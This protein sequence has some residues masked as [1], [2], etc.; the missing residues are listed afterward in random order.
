MADCNVEDLMPHSLLQQAGPP[1]RVLALMFALTWAI[2]WWYKDA[3]P[4]LDSIHQELF[5]EP[6]QRETT[7]L[8]FHVEEGGE[9][10]TITPKAEYELHGLV[11]SANDINILWDTYHDLWGD[12][13]NVKDLCV[14][15]GQN[16]RA[17]VLD[18]VT[19][20]NTS[21]TC[22]AEWRLGVPFSMAHLSNNH[23]LADSPQ[24]QHQLRHIGKGDQVRI[25]GYLAQYSNGPEF[26]RD[27]SLTRTDTGMGACETI[28]VTEM[29]VLAEGTPLWNQ[30]HETSRS[31]TLAAGLLVVLQLLYCMMT[32]QALWDPSHFYN[33]GVRLAM[34]GKHL[35]ALKLFSRTLFIAPEMHEAYAARAACLEALGDYE[36]A[37]RDRKRCAELM[38]LDHDELRV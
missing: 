10:Y 18:G 9:T 29:E 4:A 33:K 5:Q 12:H 14:I 16:L 7:R 15:W 38:P 3:Y 2:S 1:L 23:I 20:S 31:G 32:P 34:R 8:P 30:V 11:V 6:A 21:F 13:L 26:T 28:Y 17:E 24:L 36:K 37:L 35:K 19:F 25:K 22:W 27:T